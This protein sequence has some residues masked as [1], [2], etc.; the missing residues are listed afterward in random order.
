[1]LGQNEQSHKLFWK[2][3]SRCGV[4]DIPDLIESEKNN[5]DA[6]TERAFGEGAARDGNEM[7]QQLF[8]RMWLGDDLE[9]VNREL[10]NDLTRDLTTTKAGKDDPTVSPAYG[11]YNLARNARLISF[12]FCFGAKSKQFPGRLDRET[13]ALL[14]ELLWWRTMAKND[15]AIARKSTWWIAGSENHDLNSKTTNLLVSAIFA[16]E[17]EYASKVLLNQG[18]G[19]APG[20]MKEGFNPLSI[21]DPKRKGTG[22]ANWADGKV[23]TSADHYEAWVAFFKEYMLERVKK[24]FFLENGSPGYMRY[25]VSYLLLLYNFCPDEQLKKQTK[26]FLDLF[27]TDWALQQLGGL[28]G[29]PKTRHHHS[30]GSYDAMSD[31]ARFYLG[32][33]GM[34]NANYSQ[35]FLGDYEWSPLIWELVLDREGLGSFAYV[36]RGVG[37]EEE[38][39]PR[40]YGVERTMTGNRESRMTKYS[41]VT[42]DY[43]LG[44]QMDHPLAVHNHL[45]THGRWQGL[46][47]SDLNSRI[48]TVSLEPFGGKVSA[49]GEYSME[50]MYHS[51]QNQQVLITQQKRRWMQINPDWF[52]T[53]DQLYDVGFG[54]YVGSG[55]QTRIEQ[56]GWLFLEQGDTYAAIRILRLKSDPDPLAFAKGT[57]QYAHH[58]EHEEVSYTWNEGRTILRLVNKFSPIIIEAGRRADYPTLADFQQQILANKLDIHKTVATHETKIIVVYKGVEADEIVFNAANPADV[59]TIGGETIDY[60]YPKTFDAPCLQADYDRGVVTVGKGDCAMVMDFRNAVSG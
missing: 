41:W 39:C 17:P 42:P 51:V 14:L 3:I 22:R 7:D 48:V 24:G 50:L 36:A 20:Y 60:T 56:D 5:R 16:D 33:A 52:P 8:D 35:Q 10:Q 2:Q 29:G 32:G 57:D 30:A 31:W 37:E 26:M 40:P 15:I 1:M 19:C 34:S 47:T 4:S 25:T 46:T 53:Y 23:Y 44:T 49:D 13:E 18:Y 43:V 58:V 9:T 38:T 12:Y 59:P 6:R 55:W 27:W 54:V 45:S 21:D 28:R 11:L